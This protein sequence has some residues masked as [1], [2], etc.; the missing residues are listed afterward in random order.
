MVKIFLRMLS[1]RSIHVFFIIV[2]VWLQ[3]PYLQVEC[4]LL[5]EE[6]LKNPIQAQSHAAKLEKAVQSHI[7]TLETALAKGKR[8]T[9]NDYGLMVLKTLVDAL[10]NSYKIRPPDYW[11][12][13]Q[14]R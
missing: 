7:K 3:S 12:S 8:P 1:N 9:Q 6:G 2:M 14:G 11:Y 10:E 5:V 4:V 13:R